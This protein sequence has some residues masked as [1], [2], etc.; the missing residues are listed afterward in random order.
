MSYK[1]SIRES[2]IMSKLIL[3]GLIH[4]RSSVLPVFCAALLALVLFVSV[5]VQLNAAT[6]TCTAQAELT[7]AD[8]AALGDVSAR[9]LTAIQAQDSSTL[10]SALLSTE[11][12]DWPAIHT[13]ADHASALIEG[14]VLKI[15]NLYLID[16]SSQKSTADTQV[17]CSNASGSLTVT[18][19]LRA[20][21]PGKYAVVLADAVGGKLAGQVGLILGA[22]GG[23]WKLGGISAHEGILDGHDGVWYWAHARELA[24]ND[25]P[26]ASLFTYE[27]ASYLLVPV[28]YL[29]SPN[30]DKLGQEQSQVMSALKSPLTFPYTLTDGPRSWKVA[31]INID[32]TLHH[33]DLAI[34]FESMGTTDP[35]SARTEAVAVMT[36]FLKS[37]PGIRENFHGLWARATKDGKPGFAIELPMSQIPQ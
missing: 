34:V 17:F 37:Q 13:E 16:A 31:A 33:S 20:L 19:T 28:N 32:P 1:T 18:I 21:P 4:P 24:K 25:F 7:S 6:P 22:E 36:A 14:G 27:L 12:A 35:A 15:R 10:Q 29:S 9:I 23:I 5:P 3:S 2:Q 8:K 30:L 11:S 26:A